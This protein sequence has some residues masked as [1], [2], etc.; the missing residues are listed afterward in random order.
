MHHLVK[1]IEKI[2]TAD[3]ILGFV[4]DEAYGKYIDEIGAD[5]VGA[6]DGEP[7]GFADRLI[8]IES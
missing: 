6:V 2:G 5:R 4:D 8:F 1:D 3:E 7:Y